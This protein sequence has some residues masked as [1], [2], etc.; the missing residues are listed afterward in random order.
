MCKPEKEKLLFMNASANLYVRRI[1][2]RCFMSC[3]QQR[4]L[5]IFDVYL[6]GGAAVMS[7]ATVYQTGDVASGSVPGYVKTCAG[8]KRPRTGEGHS[9]G[10]TA[11]HLAGKPV[12]PF[13]LGNVQKMIA[14]TGGTL[15]RLHSSSTCILSCRRI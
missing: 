9:A 6:I 2:M 15:S 14:P 5:S 8:E 1:F 13:S 11:K 3:N 12:P 10:Q 7:L 4:T